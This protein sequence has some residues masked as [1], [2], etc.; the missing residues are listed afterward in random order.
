MPVTAL[1]IV[2]SKVLANGAVILL[3]IVNLFQRGT[4]R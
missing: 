3:A 1:E 4:P 2:L